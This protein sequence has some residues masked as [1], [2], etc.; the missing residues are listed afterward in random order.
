MVLYIGFSD[1]HDGSR[2]HGYV[3]EVAVLPAPV[4]DFSLE[5]TDSFFY[6]VT[7]RKSV[8][9]PADYYLNYSLILEF[10]FDNLFFPDSDVF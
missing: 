7:E 9:R 3:K 10:E 4:V 6:R 1:V 2:S 8:D 5:I